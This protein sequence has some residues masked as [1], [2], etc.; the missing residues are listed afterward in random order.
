[1]LSKPLLEAAAKQGTVM[2]AL[3]DWAMF[4]VFGVNFLTHVQKAGIDYYL[5]AALDQVSHNTGKKA[6][7]C[8]ENRGCMREIRPWD[9][10]FL[11][12]V[13]GSITCTN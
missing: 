6:C 2:V 5:I 10:S 1:M 12:T 4:D 11:R 13:T 7:G 3:A 8:Y 9:Q